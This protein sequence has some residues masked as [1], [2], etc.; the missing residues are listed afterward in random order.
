MTT[1]LDTCIVIALTKGSDPF[2]LWAV[3]TL[4]DAKRNSPPAA[5]CDISF[6]E[7]SVAYQSAEDLSAV[8]D[9]LGIDRLPTSDGA[10]YVAGQTF[11]AYRKRGGLKDGVLPDFIIGAVAQIEGI[12]LV[13]ANSKDFTKNFNGLMLIEPPKVQGSAPLPITP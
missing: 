7:A 5:I 10:L 11:K 1:I 4:K 3:E 6:A 12:S 2:H 13:T 9:G 8:L